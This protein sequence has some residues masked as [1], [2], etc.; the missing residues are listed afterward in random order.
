[1]TRAYKQRRGE[2]EGEGAV[3][4]KVGLPLLKGGSLVMVGPVV[5]LSAGR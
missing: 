3:A 2:G 4:V 1:M 5:D